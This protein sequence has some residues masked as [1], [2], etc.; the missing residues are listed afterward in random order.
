MRVWIVLREPRH[1]VGGESSKCWDK[2]KK[3]YSKEKYF[4]VPQAI[5]KPAVLLSVRQELRISFY[6]VQIRVQQ[7]LST[8]YFCSDHE[9]RMVITSFNDFFK[10]AIFW[11]MRSKFHCLKIKMYWNPAKLIC[12]YIFCGCFCSIKS[13]IP[14]GQLW[15]R[16]YLNLLLHNAGGLTTN[17]SDLKSILNVT[18][19]MMTQCNVFLVFIISV[20]L[21]HLNK[22]EKWTSNAM[23]RHSGV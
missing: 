8:T 7:I 14:V 2:Q 6:I 18:H 21:P 23:L 1:L 4:K 17:Y 12:L 10:K 11:H 19:I 5:Y 16:L 15:L 13:V 20:Y 3:N 22:K 9:L